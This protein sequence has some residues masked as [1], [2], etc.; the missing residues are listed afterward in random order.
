[1]DASQTNGLH[2][3]PSKGKESWSGLLFATGI[4]YSYG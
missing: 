3:V 1:M 2:F 4:H